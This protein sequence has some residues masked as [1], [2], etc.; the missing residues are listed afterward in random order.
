[1]KFII[2][3]FLFASPTFA[4]SLKDV[5]IKADKTSYELELMVQHLKN[6]VRD[7]VLVEN[8]IKYLSL[9]NNDLKFSKR[10]YAL[11]LLKTEIYRSILNYDLNITSSL[12]INELFLKSLEQKLIKHKLTY[13][14]FTRWMIGSMISDIRPYLKSNFSDSS[15]AQMEMQNREY[16]KILKF[17]GPWLISFEKLTPEGFISEVSQMSIQTLKTIS[18]KTFLYSAFAVATSDEATPLFILPNLEES[19]SLSDKGEK[20]QT[21]TTQ[22]PSNAVAP[23]KLEEITKPED[24]SSISEELDKIQNEATNKPEEIW[25][26][27]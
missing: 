13:T 24:L 27:E 11:F 9:I 14:D 3:F 22:E 19:P 20:P 7:P 16:K 8:V 26:P 23:D 25:I 6:E 1:M 15:N 17:V 5:Q 18:H 12:L 2:L 10:S 4:Q 21:S